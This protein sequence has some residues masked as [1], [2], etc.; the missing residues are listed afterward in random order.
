MNKTYIEERLASERK[1]L[2]GMVSR[3]GELVAA[4]NEL[5][6]KINQI[7]GV[8]MAYEDL[9]ERWKDQDGDK[10]EDTESSRG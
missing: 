3:H 1:S 10:R 6:K 2:A 9:L 4:A 8:I 5:K 7:E